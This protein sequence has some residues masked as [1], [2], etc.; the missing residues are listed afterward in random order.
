[1]DRLQIA[2]H[3]KM[4]SAPNSRA[5]AGRQRC[6]IPVVLANNIDH[7]PLMLMLLSLLLSLQPMLLLLLPLAASPS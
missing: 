2:L 7:A 1:M 4:R 3:A 6:N 5:P